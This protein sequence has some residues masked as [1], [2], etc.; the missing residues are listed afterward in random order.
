MKKIFFIICISFLFNL[1]ILML[2][3]IKLGNKIKDVFEP[4]RSFKIDLPPGEWVVT[5]SNSDEFYGLRWKSYILVRL[6]NYKFV[7]AIAFEEI[8]TAGVYEY[9]VND[10]LH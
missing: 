10:C 1:V 4:V 3:V 5:Q 9:V 2:Q 7:E 6:D 8:H